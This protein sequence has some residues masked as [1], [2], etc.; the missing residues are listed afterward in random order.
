MAYLFDTDAISEVLKRRP[1]AAYLRWLAAIPRAEQFCSAVSVGELYRGAFRAPNRDR[2]L[3]NIGQRVIP[4]LTVL[5]YDLR[6]ARAYGQITAA[7]E[8]AGRRL[9]DA[10]LQIAATAICHDLE[11]VTGNLRHFERI[12]N[13]RINRILAEQKR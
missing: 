13:L 11:L 3:A 1:N 8:A 12:S 10:D 7:L 5:P 2:H 4:A 9:A 6:T